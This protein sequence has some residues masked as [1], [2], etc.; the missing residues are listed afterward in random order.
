[1]CLY[2]FVS[3]Q[4]QQTF[5]KYSLY[6]TRRRMSS[7]GDNKRGLSVFEEEEEEDKKQTFDRI[8]KVIFL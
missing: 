1:M 6:C 3:N 7:I 4:N 8:T 2:T 5:Q